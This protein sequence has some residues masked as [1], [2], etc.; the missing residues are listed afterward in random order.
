MMAWCFSR[1]TKNEHG[2]P[3]SA[4]SISYMDIIYIYASA[5][6]VVRDSE[7]VSGDDGDGNDEN[8]DG[9]DAMYT[10]IRIIRQIE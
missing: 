10:N 5:A 6:T 4:V 7:Y 2:N 1:A 9:D 3:Q 8:D